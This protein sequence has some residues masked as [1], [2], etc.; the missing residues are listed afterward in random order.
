[1]PTALFSLEAISNSVS[2]GRAPIGAA[3]VL[4]QG[5]EKEHTPFAGVG[6]ILLFTADMCGATLFCLI[7]AGVAISSLAAGAVSFLYIAAYAPIAIDS[8]L[9]LKSDETHAVQ[10]RQALIDL[11]NAVTQ[12]ALIVV[13]LLAAPTPLI[14]VLA[15]GAVLFGSMSFLHRIMT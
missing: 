5:Y 6:N 4:R 2:L 3:Y 1:M 13:V 14:I 7:V 12:I 15:G 9:V 11:A 10:K 8:V